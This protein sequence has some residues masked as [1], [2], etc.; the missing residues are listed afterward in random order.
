MSPEQCRKFNIVYLADMVKRAKKAGAGPSVLYHLCGSH[1]LD[2]PIH[3]ELC[4]LDEATMF[5]VA[6]YGR[7]PADLTD[8]I[9]VVG[10]K[11]PILG[12]MPTELLHLGNAREVYEETKRQILTYRHSPKGFI[13]GV[14]CECPPKAPLA[15][16]YS[17][18][19][20][21]KEIGPLPKK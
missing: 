1:E 12:N 13:M 20:A 16:V 6:Y 18:V 5:H 9:P 3:A 14:A 11:C 2:W 21:S 15:N 17:M 19:K 8:V 4:P 7:K 10:S